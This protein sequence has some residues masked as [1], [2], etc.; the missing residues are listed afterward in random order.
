M[1]P[2]L[3]K[4]TSKGAWREF[5]KQL[6]LSWCQHNIMLILITPEYAWLYLWWHVCGP[7]GLGFCLRRSQV[8]KFGDFLDDTFIQ[9]K[10]TCPENSIL[11]RPATITQHLSTLNLIIDLFAQFS[12]R[13]ISFPNWV[14]SVALFIGKYM[15][16]PSA[17]RR[18]SDP[19]SATMSLT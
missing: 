17:K 11:P 10:T 15:M 2:M 9:K 19:I 14:M 12:R 3:P 4:S 8:S 13:S 1:D 16:T 6:T 18:I 5:C 7:P